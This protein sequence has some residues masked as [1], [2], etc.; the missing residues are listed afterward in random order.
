MDRIWGSR[1]DALNNIMRITVGSR[2]P[3]GLIEDTG[4]KTS[5]L[6]DYVLYLHTMYLENKLD[7]AT[8]IYTQGQ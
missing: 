4:V 5:F 2:R 6:L 3:I 1:K 8:E 7:L